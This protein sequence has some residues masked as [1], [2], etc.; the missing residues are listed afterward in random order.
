MEMTKEMLFSIVELLG[1]KDLKKDVE[2]TINGLESEDTNIFDAIKSELITFNNN[3]NKEILGK[4]Y[5]QEAKKTERLIK[6]IFTNIDFEATKKDEM[7]TELRDKHK[8]NT[9]S[10]GSK[11][12]TLQDA[13][14]VPEIATHFE[15][16]QN[17]GKEFDN[18]Q[19]QFDAYKNLQ[20]V[21]GYAMDILPTIGAQFSTNDRLKKV[22]QAELEKLLSSLPHKIIDGKVIVLDEDGDP[23]N[24]PDTSKAF[25]FQDYLKN[26][27]ALDFKALEEKPKDNNPP[28]PTKGGNTGDFGYTSE[29]RKSLTHEDY[30][31]AKAAGKPQEAE[32]IKNAINDN[33]EAFNKE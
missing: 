3:R 33:L 17:K 9:E 25:E 22:Q 13:L 14:K 18:L 15:A 11:K 30:R 12:I 27:V 29:R 8:V 31:A 16:L 5:R 6:E 4:G 20:S 26:N 32:F 1:S 28:I 21:K 10:K 7:L 2:T 23:L 24:N 19:S